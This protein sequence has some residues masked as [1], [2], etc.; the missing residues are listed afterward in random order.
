MYVNVYILVHIK[1]N[2]QALSLNY[3][4]NYFTGQLVFVGIGVIMFME[5]S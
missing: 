1:S 2:V 4:F 5:F 3:F